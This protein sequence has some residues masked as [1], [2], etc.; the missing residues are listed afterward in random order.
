M[1]DAGGSLRCAV[2]GDKMA[3][4][5]IRNGWRGLIINGC[6]R[7]AREL[8]TMP[9]CVKALGTNPVRGGK[10]AVGTVGAALQWGGVIW[11]PGSW[12]SCDLDGIIVAD[13]EL[14]LGS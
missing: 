3:S 8:K 2:V 13:S 9:L 1:V 6:V 12:C 4:L 7:D 5:A 14:R 10:A 11:R